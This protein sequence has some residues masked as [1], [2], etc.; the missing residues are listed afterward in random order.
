MDNHGWRDKMAKFPDVNP[1]YEDILL[2]IGIPHK[3]WG[4]S[5]VSG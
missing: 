3:Q 5:V 4:I 2:S 1:V